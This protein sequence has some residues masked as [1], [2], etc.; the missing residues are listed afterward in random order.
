MSLFKSTI[1][2]CVLAGALWA[3]PP[4]SLTGQVLDPSGAA[5]PAASISV[6]G[7]NNTVKVAQSATDGSYSVVALPPG[8]YTVRASAPGFTLFEANV[9]LPGG[10]ASTLDI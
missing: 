10:R 5:V 2:I 4:G 9:N 7:P 3:Q 6:S 8:Q 1:A